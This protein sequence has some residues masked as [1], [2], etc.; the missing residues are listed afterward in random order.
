[1]KAGTPGRTVGISSAG[2]GAAGGFGGGDGGV[3]G[4]LEGGLLSGL[5]PIRDRYLLG[6]LSKMNAPILQM[7]PD[8]DGYTAAVP[9][10][11]DLQALLKALVGEMSQ[12]MLDG[13]TELGLLHLVCRESMKSVHLMLSKIEGMASTGPESK[14]L[15]PGNGFAKNGLQEHNA[16]LITLVHNFRD[17]L[18]KLPGTL[19]KMAQ[20]SSAFSQS[21]MS[22]LSSAASDLRPAEGESAIL[23]RVKKEVETAVSKSTM[24]I[25]ELLSRQ[26]LAPIVEVISTYAQSCLL[27]MLKEG[28]SVSS[29]ISASESGTTSESIDG[30]NAVIMLTQNLPDIFR[31]Y[32]QSLP[33]SVAVQNAIQETL[34][35]TLSM[36][37]TVAS[38]QRPINEVA[39]LRIA[40]DMTALE[41]SLLS[42]A[43]IDNAQNCPV[44]REFK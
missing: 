39:R 4:D 35:R 8:L 34:L 19:V 29:T 44:T 42:I 26:L 15:N 7:F 31:I 9:S 20:D 2:K 25:D 12:A 33:R 18:E 11:R 37:T 30:S 13:D 36:F 3:E 38:L 23:D 14:K 22:S 43:T 17:G 32:L 1:M 24:M 5:R 10:K 27:G 16:Q 28:V 40:K 41:A 21:G 6:A